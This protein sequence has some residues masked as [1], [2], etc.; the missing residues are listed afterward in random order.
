MIR[1]LARQMLVAQIF[2]ALTVSLCLMIDSIVIGRFLG[3]EAI[4][5]YG[6]SNP[7]LLV[8]GAVGSLLASGIQAAC[9]KSL[10][11]GSQEE[12]NAGYSSAIAVG[13]G[14]SLLFVALVLLFTSPLATL[15]RAGKSGPLFEQTRDYLTG[16]SIGAPASMG[17]L[18]LVPFLQMAGKSGLL[19]A[20]V[21]SMTV[22]DIALDMLNVL[23]FHWGMFGM[24][25]ASSLS[26]YLALVIAGFYFLSKKCV[27]RFSW[28]LVTRRKIAEL[29][30]NGIPAGIGMVTSVILV[31]ALN[32]LL[33]DKGGSRAVAAYSVI[34][35]I[36]N[37]SNCIT[38]GIGG[39]SLTLSGIFYN[40][41]DRTS[42]R[43]LIRYLCRCGVFLG[44]GVG[45][46][47]MLFAPIFVSLFI[48]N[49]GETQNMAALGLRL[50]AIGLI[51]CCINNALKNLYQAS[52]RIAL[53]EII[54]TFEGVVLPLLAAFVF[55]LMIGTT[56]VW[57]YFGLGE[58]LTLVSIAVYIYRKT[59]IL[60][61]KQEAVLL[62]KENF[63]A[64]KERMLE[65]D[66]HSLE[67]VESVVRQ[68][69]QFCLQHGQNA[70]V[71]NHIALCIEEMAGNIIQHGFSQDA[72]K[73]HVSIR[74]ISKEEYWVLR[75]RD[76][77]RA[78]DPVHYVPRENE[79]ALGIRLVLAIA[80]DAQYTYSLNLNNLTLK[81]R[82]SGQKNMEC[83]AKTES[84]IEPAGASLI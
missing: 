9:S 25:L 52:E 11:R 6:L 62:L 23:V 43:A 73:H 76:D 15:M 61:W 84:N 1:K 24:G 27:F 13:G 14:I 8:M 54:S 48:P 7:V 55:S 75:F 56:G 18:V 40:E 72:N 39:V 22:A 36:G 57:L 3:E 29:F 80:E 49:A 47:L 74:L 71:S 51:P 41:E 21:L 64:V 33:A 82:G 2:A 60:P 79:D 65:V 68:A 67:E 4:A 63:G 28:K 17:A 59:G 81:L 30:R 35:T 37:A 58:F 46:V 34:M 31:F 70:K 26:Y 66:V 10:G 83:P 77:C 69:E 53:T 16:F 12:T 32:N 19:I 45:V 78:F 20:A 42:L 38:T 44:A 50:F 5:A